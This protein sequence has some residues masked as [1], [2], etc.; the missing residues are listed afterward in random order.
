MWFVIGG[1]TTATAVLALAVLHLLRRWRAY[2]EK[3]EAA[4]YRSHRE[5][6]E[7]S[8]DVSALMEQVRHRDKRAER[9]QRA[10]RVANSDA[11]TQQFSPGQ[12]AYGGHVPKQQNRKMANA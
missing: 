9:E 6:T 8:V 3:V 2:E 4:R 1:T 5:G 11:P 12:F 7:D 10:A